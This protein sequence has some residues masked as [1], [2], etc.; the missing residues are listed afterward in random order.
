MKLNLS[1]ILFIFLAINVSCNKENDPDPV[2]TPL[3]CSVTQFRS[4][5]NGMLQNVEYT[6]GKVSKVTTTFTSDQITEYR[7]EFAYENDEVIE[8]FTGPSFDDL[9]RYKLGINGRIERSAYNPDW[10]Y[11]WFANIF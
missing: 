3:P 2:S 5:L 6:N 1:F 8:T 11:K 10:F 9:T 4:N 7:S